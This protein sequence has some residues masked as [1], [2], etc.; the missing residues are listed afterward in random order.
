MKTKREILSWWE[1]LG[2]KVKNNDYEEFWK[3][4]D[5]NLAIVEKVK[6]SGDKQEHEIIIM[7]RAW[8]Y[9]LRLYFHNLECYRI[10]GF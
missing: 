7:S 6:G 10:V 3:K 1:N 8:K 5:K 2:N 4:I 9:P